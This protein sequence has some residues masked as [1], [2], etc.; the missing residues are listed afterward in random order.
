MHE[1]G[2]VQHAIQGIR[3]LKPPRNELPIPTQK[4][5]KKII[6]NDDAAEAVINTWHTQ[7]IPPELDSPAFFVYSEAGEYVKWLRS[8][9]EAINAYDGFLLGV[10]DKIEKFKKQTQFTLDQILDVEKHK[11]KLYESLEL[12]KFTLRRIRAET[13]KALRCQGNLGPQRVLRLL[14]DTIRRIDTADRT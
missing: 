8:E 6:V 10:H 7:D 12:Y 13:L 4:T 1:L 14:K 5:A 11:A 2:N 3:A 9:I